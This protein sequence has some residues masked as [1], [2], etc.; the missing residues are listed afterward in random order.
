MPVLG[1]VLFLLARALDSHRGVMSYPDSSG[2]LYL[3]SHSFRNLYQVIRAFAVRPILPQIFFAL[4]GRGSLMTEVQIGASVFSWSYLAREVWRRVTLPSVGVAVGLFV[5]SASV[6]ANIV[7]WNTALLSESLALSILA[8]AIGLLLSLQRKYSKRKALMAALVIMALPLTRD[9]YIW[10]TPFMLVA[11]LVARGEDGNPSANAKLVAGGVVGGVLEYLGYAGVGA[12]NPTG[13]Y[14]NLVLAPLNDDL[15]TRILRSPAAL[16]FFERHGL[17]PTGQLLRCTGR[18]LCNG[19]ETYLRWA[20]SHLAL[21]YCQWLLSQPI[22]TLSTFIR[23]FP[24][25]ENSPMMAEGYTGQLHGGRLLVDISL[26]L[27]IGQGGWV[28]T[29]VSV[30][31]GSALVATIAMRR[32]DL[33]GAKQ[34]TAN[35]LLLPAILVMGFGT[36]LLLDYWGDSQ[37]LWRHS[38]ES[39]VGLELA[40]VVLFVGAFNLLWSVPATVDICQPMPNVGSGEA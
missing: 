2:Y 37:E 21:T 13:R 28:V 27:P 35:Q 12:A 16:A 3:S 33:V 20:R 40:A 31:V 25:Y 24:T 32:S 14:P 23:A 29:L 26:H 22:Y 36:S 30:G 4:L 34:T 15:G 5:A 17:V 10:G 39:V 7:A 6:S 19:G 9:S 38:L 18:N 11:L 1:L 8:A